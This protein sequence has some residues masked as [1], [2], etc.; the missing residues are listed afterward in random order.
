MLYSPN[1]KEDSV[2]SLAEQACSELA[3]ISKELQEPKAQVLTER[4]FLYE[5]FIFS[6]MLWGE[7]QREQRSKV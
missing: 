3:S 1:G 4:K 6:R 7:Y 2:F 5:H